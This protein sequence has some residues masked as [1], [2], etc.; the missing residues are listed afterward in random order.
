MMSPSQFFCLLV[1]WVQESSTATVMTQTP[2]SLSVTLGETV[3]ISCRASQ[4]ISNY[5]AWYQLSPGKPPKSLI[6]AATYLPSGIPA[7]FSGSGYGTDFTLK[8]SPVEA[9]DVAD[10]YCLQYN[11]YPLPQ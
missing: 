3:T 6:Y 2:A 1:L 7:R 8:I 10:Y 11:Q 4:S 9:E 5:L